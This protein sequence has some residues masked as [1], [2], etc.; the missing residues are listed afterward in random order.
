[1]TEDTREPTAEEREKAIQAQADEDWRN[2]DFWTAK[3][4]Y[5]LKG[6]DLVMQEMAVTRTEAIQLWASMQHDNAANVM[7]RAIHQYETMQE[8]MRPHIKSLAE[9]A[10]KEMDDAKDEPWKAD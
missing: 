5:C 4:R 2:R 10:Q 6:I 8:K 1:M 3:C 7:L 9:A